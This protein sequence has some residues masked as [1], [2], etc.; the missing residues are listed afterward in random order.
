MPWLNDLGLERLDHEFHTLANYLALARAGAEVGE[1]HGMI[2][3]YVQA[4]VSKV[5]ATSLG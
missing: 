4:V 2:R 1:V 3:A 5:A